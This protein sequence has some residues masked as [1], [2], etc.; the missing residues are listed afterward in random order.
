MSHQAYS[1]SFD[2]I[3]KDYQAQI[4]VPFKL[5]RKKKKKNSIVVF[6]TSYIYIIYIK[7]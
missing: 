6:N 2:E 5:R 1:F 3:T 7:C 4:K